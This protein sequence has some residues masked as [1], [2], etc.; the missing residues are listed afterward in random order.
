MNK[1][2]SINANINRMQQYLE[3][4]EGTNWPTQRDLN[5]TNSSA[6]KHQNEIFYTNKR[7]KL[8]FNALMNEY[9]DISL[10]LNQPSFLFIGNNSRNHRINFKWNVN[11]HQGDDYNISKVEIEW[12][13]L[14]QKESE[15]NVDRLQ[16]H[17]NQMNIY[18]HSIDT[19]DNGQYS[20]RIK[21]FESNLGVW[22]KFSDFRSVSIYKIS[23]ELIDFNVF[24][25]NYIDV[26]AEQRMIGGN[27]TKKG[28]YPRMVAASKG[29]TD[30]VYEWKIK[31][32]HYD[33]SNQSG[34][35]SHAIGIFTNPQIAANGANWVND[36]R[37]NC[38]YYWNSFRRTIYGAINGEYVYENNVN[39][40][41]KTGDVIIILLD[42]NKWTIQFSK[43]GNVINSEPYKIKPN[44]TYYPMIVMRS[45]NDQYQA[46]SHH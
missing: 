42:C 29:Y 11:V 39:D 23:E 7:A 21:Y 13:D 44:K 22:S 2:S 45:H 10:P 17:S 43:N 5:D 41:W 19:Q 26:D 32:V 46:V 4:E 27:G 33:H 8:R 25:S 16:V 9:G 40:G 3:N 20:V 24:D 15:E 34:N 28:K 37:I 35:A 38:A 1:T 12:K 6:Q 31:C 18:E 30:G 36:V 14:D